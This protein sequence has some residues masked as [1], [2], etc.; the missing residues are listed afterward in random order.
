MTSLFETTARP[1]PSFAELFTPKLMTVLREGYGPRQFHADAIAGLT[2]AIVALPLSMAIAIASGVSPERGLYTAI[3]GG[4]LVSALGGSRFQI[5]GPAGAFI[6]LGAGIVER[7]GYDGL[8]LA[9][10]MAGIVMIAVGLMR[11][12]TYVKYI[13]F[14]VTVGFTAG[15]AVIIFASQLKELLGLAVPNEPAA[16][17][18]KLEALWQARG[19]INLQAVAI[20]VATVLIILGLRKWRPG[21]PAF[22]IAITAAAA[23]TWA[24]DFDVVTIASRFGE[25]PRSLS[26]PGLPPFSLGKAQAVLPDAA[27][28]ALLGAIESLLSAVVAD[29]MSGRRHRSN[30]EL[31]AQ[32]TA[33]IGSILFGGIPVTGTIAR[34]ATNIRSGAVG[35]I[36]GMLHS[37]FLFLFMLV[38]APLA[39]FLPLAALGAVLAVVAWNMA[40]REDF[41]LLLRSSRG[42][43]IVLLTTFLLTVFVDL[44]T[45]ISVGVVLG[46]FVFLHR[47]AESVEVQGHGQLIVDDEPD[48]YSDTRAYDPAAFSDRDIV[49]YR[50]SGAFFFGATAAVSGVLERIGRP[51]VFVLDFSDV[52][53]VDSTGAKTLKRL[54]EKLALT[55]TL[56][57]ITGA[58]LKV[59]RSLLLAGLSKPIIRYAKTADQAVRFSR[60]RLDQAATA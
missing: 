48:D 44:T 3:I 25:L 35:P 21:W 30:C 16:F 57:F 15:I 14:P 23:L 24:L 6:V 53:M 47:M 42:D 5:G 20:G 50:I 58:S 18:P 26:Q 38:A 27:A 51:R 4:F 54:A 37:L 36:S 32:G 40:E 49:V 10:L 56:I 34:T 28:I 9:T 7:H 12:G 1:R 52:P 11:L 2:V 17:L 31:V 39:G 45:G 8:A 41:I 55:G 19:S 33:N 43:R 46:A 22:L 60:A 59:R 13:P 29:G